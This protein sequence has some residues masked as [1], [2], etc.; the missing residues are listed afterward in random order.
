VAAV[1]IFSV[2]AGMLVTLSLGFRFA[3]R[4]LL[5]SRS[6]AASITLFLFM[7]IALVQIVANY[8]ENL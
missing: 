7:A 6:V 5:A 4:Q 1:P 8:S 2:L 3:D